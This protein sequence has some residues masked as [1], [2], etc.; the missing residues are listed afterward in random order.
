[1]DLT[2]P[3][4]RWLILGIVLY[5]IAI[6]FAFTQQAPNSAKMLELAN[7]PPPAGVVPAGPPPEIVALGKKLARG[8]QFLTIMIVIIVILMVTKPVG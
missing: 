7:T 2:K 4:W 1:V 8:G 3:E 6:V 5:A